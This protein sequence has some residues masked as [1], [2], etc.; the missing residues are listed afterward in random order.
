M[1]R[2]RRTEITIETHQVLIL[3]RRQSSDLMSCEQCR[4]GRSPLVTPEVAGSLTGVNT[5]TVYRWV[6]AGRL[7]YTETNNGGL[8][9]CLASL[10]INGEATS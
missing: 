2:K 6:E 7:H 3:N 1:W 5:R 4:T 9:V 8:F 10:P